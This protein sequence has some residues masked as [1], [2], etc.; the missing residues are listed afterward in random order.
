M[1]SVP[2]AAPRRATCARTM[3]RAVARYA[4]GLLFPVGQ[5]V[6]EYVPGTSGLDATT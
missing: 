2:K 4:Q 6:D 5:A 1:L 3:A